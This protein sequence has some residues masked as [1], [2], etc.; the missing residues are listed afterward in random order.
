MIDKLT[1][2]QATRVEQLRSKVTAVQ[3]QLAPTQRHAFTTY[4]TCFLVRHLIARKWDVQGAFDMIM[5]A[6]RWRNETNLDGIPLF[7]ALSVV[8]GFPE[9]DLIKLRGC[10]IRQPGELDYAMKHLRKVAG[11]AWH[12]WDKVGRPVY[13]ERTG[14]FQP[15]PIIERLRSIHKPG[16]D[17]ALLP[18]AV[19]AQ[20]NEVGATIVR[21]CNEMGIAKSPVTCVTIIM[22]GEGLSTEHLYGPVLDILKSQGKHD[23][24]YYAEGLYRLYVVNCPTIISAIWNIVKF[25]IDER[26]RTKVNFIKPAET[27]KTLLEVIDAENLPVWLGG[28]CACEGECVPDAGCDKEDVPLGPTRECTVSAGKKDVVEVPITTSSKVEYFVHVAENDINFEAAFVAG[29]A[30]GGKLVV[31]NVEKHTGLLQG[32]FSGA[33]ADGKITFTFDNSYSWL[34]AK[35]YSYLI[36]VDGK[37]FGAEGCS[38]LIGDF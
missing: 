11:A 19:H 23:E 15:R 27:A 25:W 34:K 2:T 18:I 5:A 20:S 38:P 13:I 24:K 10:G 3:D 35:T 28:K 9:E 4:R 30:G 22:D 16:A 29:A 12:K 21:Y 8:R 17:I 14:H 26:T 32:E 33:P 36:L 37:P 31:K 1:D 7:P 6:A